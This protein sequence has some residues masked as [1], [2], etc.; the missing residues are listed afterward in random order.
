M[1][2]TLEQRIARQRALRLSGAPQMQAKRIEP[3]KPDW[4]AP[5]REEPRT[6]EHWHN[7]RPKRSAMQRR[8]WGKVLSLD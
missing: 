6:F 8:E 7:T 5:E 4:T 3:R 1:T 2:E